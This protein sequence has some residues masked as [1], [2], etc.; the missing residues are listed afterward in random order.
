MLIWGRSVYKEPILCK[1]VA[2]SACL[3]TFS[4]PMMAVAYCPML[5]VYAVANEKN[6]VILKGPHDADHGAVNIAYTCVGLRVVA[7]SW[8][9]SVSNTTHVFL[10][11]LAVNDALSAKS[12]SPVVAG[13]STASAMTT[14]S[15]LRFDAK[16]QRSSRVPCWNFF[17]SLH[18]LTWSPHVISME[19]ESSF[20]LCAFG[21]KHA[22]ILSPSPL[23]AATPDS[24]MNTV[25]RADN[26]P[27]LVSETQLRIS[28]T[29]WGFRFV[30]NA[31]GQ[32]RKLITQLVLSHIGQLSILE[33]YFPSNCYSLLF[34]V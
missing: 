34:A 2:F 17:Y 1:E 23:F 24:N 25:A 4:L 33:W 11:I 30:T 6:E 19:N 3:L 32:G 18:G 10:A 21:P 20:A 28:T 9:P 16:A 27:N 7:L 5:D 26:T 14:I 12:P 13:A 8:S 15:M 29:A 31:Q 22:I